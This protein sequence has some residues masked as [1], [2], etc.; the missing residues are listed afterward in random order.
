MDFSQFPERFRAKVLSTVVRNM[1]AGVSIRFGELREGVLP[2]TVQQ[3]D[4][5]GR[6][7]LSRRELENLARDAFATLPYKLRFTQLRGR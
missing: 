6:G 3:T 2:L 1:R 4:T 5:T 7:E